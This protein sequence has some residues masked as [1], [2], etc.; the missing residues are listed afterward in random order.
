M[1]YFTK[2]QC[3]VY[4]C[5]LYCIHFQTRLIIYHLFYQL[6]LNAA[7]TKLDF[8]RFTRFSCFV[9]RLLVLMEIAQLGHIARAKIFSAASAANTRIDFERFFALQLLRSDGFSFSVEVAQLGHIA[10]ANFIKQMI[11][12]SKIQSDFSCRRIDFTHSIK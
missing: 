2:L 7:N 9:A 10:R 11:Q 8:E 6:G 3:N 4:S 1:A 12:A 5:P